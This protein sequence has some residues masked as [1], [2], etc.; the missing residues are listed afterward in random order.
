[1]IDAQMSDL[2]TIFQP[3]ESGVRQSMR[4]V[5]VLLS[6]MQE[7]VTSSKFHLM[8]ETDDA[9]DEN[10]RTMTELRVVFSPTIN[11][12]NPSTSKL[13]LRAVGFMGLVSKAATTAPDFDA[14]PS[15]P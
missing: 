14:P 8:L 11:P 2:D 6:Q 5:L 9:P 13:L 4:S 10:G 12:N 7:A 1:M 3:M 15:P